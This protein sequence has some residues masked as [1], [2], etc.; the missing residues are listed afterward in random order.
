MISNCHNILADKPIFREVLLLWKGLLQC[1]IAQ[2][3]KVRTERWLDGRKRRRRRRRDLELKNCYCW[4][5]VHR[6]GLWIVSPRYGWHSSEATNRGAAGWSV[7]SQDQTISSRHPM[8][9]WRNSKSFVF[10]L[11]EG[12]QFHDFAIS[13]LIPRMQISK[14]QYCVVHSGKH[15][16]FQTSTSSFA[17]Q[18]QK[19][20]FLHKE[21]PVHDFATGWQEVN[22]SYVN[23]FPSKCFIRLYLQ[24]VEWWCSNSDYRASNARMIQEI[25]QEC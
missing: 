24:L 7:L 22:Q 3:V 2:L 15:S 6:M 11:N 12:A 25:W 9:S 18:Y 5:A 19:Q 1:V 16:L 20:A 17:W 13:K 4:C 23:D 10:L 14:Q 8:M 21:L